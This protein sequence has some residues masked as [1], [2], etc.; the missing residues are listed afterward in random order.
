MRT[1]KYLPQFDYDPVVLTTDTIE[2]IADQSMLEELPGE[3]SIYRAPLVTN[4]MIRI[5][6]NHLIDLMRSCFSWQHL[7]HYKFEWLGPALSLGSRILKKE[8]TMAILSRSTPIADHLVGLALKTV[9]GLPW[10]ADFS[11][12]WTQNPYLSCHK[13]VHNLEVGVERLVAK[14][15]DKI[16]F[17]TAYARE[18]FL[19]QHREIPQEKVEVIPNSF[20]PADYIGLTHQET[21]K[22]TITYAGNLYDQRSPESFFKALASL[23]RECSA[24]QVMVRF[25]GEMGPYKELLGKYG[26]NDIVEAQGVLPHKEVLSYLFRSDVLLLIDAPSSRPGMFL[27][28]KL[29]E[30]L[31]VGRPILALT[32][33]KGASSD[34]IEST[35]A[36]MVVPPNDEVAI[37][38]ALKDLYLRY[39]NGHLSVDVDQDEIGKYSVEQC[40]AKL[41]HILRN[42]T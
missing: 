16:I 13:L 39:E 17:T 5:I 9:S 42:L 23:R 22:F 19:R 15:S 24:R 7:S 32:P 37:R 29:V 1:A 36:G 20:D 8:R 4:D 30:Y 14:A 21:S 34:I 3:V 33:K 11:D 12:P 38:N 6:A 28:Q 35:R 31:R 18:A 26:V 41:A 40:T 2:G 25:I 27:P 10:I